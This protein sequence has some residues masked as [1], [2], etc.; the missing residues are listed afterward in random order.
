MKWARSGLIIKLMVI[1]LIINFVIPGFSGYNRAEAS[2]FQEHRDSI[3][4]L[5]K[6]AVMLYIMSIFTGDS[7]EDD[8]DF[9][10][11]T[12]EE[13]LDIGS[14][15]N[16]GNDDNNNDNE[17][18]EKNYNLSE[19]ENDVLKAVNNVRQDREIAPLSLDENLTAVA[20]KKAE[21]MV[22]NDYFGHKSPRYG[23]LFNMLDEKGISYLLAGENLIEADTEEAV[24]NKMM[25]IPENRE[26]VLEENYNRTGIGIVR[27]GSQIVVVQVFVDLPA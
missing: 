18:R 1:I 3:F 23:T 24:F 20:Q 27:E 2:F 7:S 11:S 10:T 16:T 12:I 15:D 5:L 21:D 4:T 19:L 22:E 26:N 6:G 9:L 14:S 8:G 25:E 13:G 17:E